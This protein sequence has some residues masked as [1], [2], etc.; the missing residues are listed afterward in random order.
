MSKIAN[1][2]ESMRAGILRGELEPDRWLKMEELKA[3]YAV[4]FSPLREVLSRLVGEGLVE[5]EA[6]R[7]FRVKG[8]SKADLLDIAVTRAAVE[9]MA[10]KRSIAQ[11]DDRWEAGVV[12]AM[13]HYRRKSM[14]AFDSE[15]SL[16]AWEVAHDELHAALI[17]AC[18][19]PRL[20]ALQRRLQDQHLRYRRLIVVPQVEP[21]AHVGEHQQLVDYALARDLDAAD[22]HIQRHM[23]ITV[24]ALSD[25][26]F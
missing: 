15:E 1:L 14:A 10:L 23:M 26:D 22:A 9:S 20:M 8:L 11:G 6:N 7:G 25:V 21:E 5:F 13:H 18:A 24:D 12:G 2:E 16:L 17:S 3:R 19:S 4:G